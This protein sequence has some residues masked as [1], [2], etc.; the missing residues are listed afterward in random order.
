MTAMVMTAMVM[1]AMATD[2]DDDDDDDAVDSVDSC[3]FRGFRAQFLVCS[4]V[5]GP[6]CIRKQPEA[7]RK[8]TSFVIWM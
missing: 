6:I 3:G 8:K 7:A 2:D 1:T 5:T 4:F